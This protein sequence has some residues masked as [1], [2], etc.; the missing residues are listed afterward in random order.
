MMTRSVCRTNEVAGLQR[1]S[2][3]DARQLFTYAHTHHT[4]R[5][6]GLVPG[7]PVLAPKQ[8]PYTPLFPSYDG[9]CAYV[10]V[11][12]RSPSLSMLD[13]ILSPAFSQMR[14]SGG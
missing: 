12:S 5:H 3:R 14:F 1:R 6:A 8:F 10:S 4:R 13:T 7:I 11:N 2:S 9:S